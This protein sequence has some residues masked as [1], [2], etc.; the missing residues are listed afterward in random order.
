MSLV[1]KLGNR[2]L[3][4]RAP[5]NPRRVRAR[6]P[7]P[8]GLIILGS[9]QVVLYVEALITH[10]VSNR[11]ASIFDMGN[12]ATNKMSVHRRIAGPH[13]LQ[14]RSQLQDSLRVCHLRQDQQDVRRGQGG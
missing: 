5:G 3:V 6:D 9:W 14:L 1:E 7:E 13:H 4:N 11:R 8:W 12:R 10:S 2:R